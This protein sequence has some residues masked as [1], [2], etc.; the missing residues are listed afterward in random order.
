MCSAGRHEDSQVPD[1]EDDED[2]DSGTILISRLAER[3]LTPVK[4]SNMQRLSFCAPAQRCIL[5]QICTTLGALPEEVCHSL[6]CPCHII[7]GAPLTSNECILIES[8]VLLQRY[9]FMKLT[10][11]EVSTVPIIRSA[12][13]SRSK[14]LLG[15]PIW[16]IGHICFGPV[17]QSADGNLD[18]QTTPGDYEPPFFRT[19]EEDNLAQFPS[20][21][22]SL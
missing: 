19:V 7:S 1:C 17:H 22:F 8:G 5:L 14:V 11:N 12:T 13:S 6:W 4:N 21:P 16:K 9:V 10:Y 15:T 3:C 18:M 2:A 20:R